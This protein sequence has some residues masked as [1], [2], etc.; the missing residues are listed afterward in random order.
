MGCLQRQFGKDFHKL[1]FF[2]DNSIP[3]THMVDKSLVLQCKIAVSKMVIKPNCCQ[4]DI[5]GEIL[6]IVL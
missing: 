1:E 5:K 6:I 4:S 2:I 3:R